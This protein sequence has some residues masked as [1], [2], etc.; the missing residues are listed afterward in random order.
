MWF[1]LLRSGMTPKFKTF[2]HLLN[3]TTTTTTRL[4]HSSSSDKQEDLQRLAWEGRHAWHI[5]WAEA[6][7][8]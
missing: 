5:F 4:I 3:A 7:L 6:K 2:S 1:E 8:N